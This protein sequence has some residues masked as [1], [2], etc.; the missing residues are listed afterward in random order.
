MWVMVFDPDGGGNP[1]RQTAAPVAVADYRTE[2]WSARIGERDRRRFGRRDAGRGQL[3]AGDFTG[4]GARGEAAHRPVVPSEIPDGQDA[5]ASSAGPLRR[6]RHPRRHH[7]RAGRLGRQRQ[8]QLGQSGTPAYAFGQVCGFDGAAHSSL[9]SS[10]RTPRSATAAARDH[11]VR[12][13]AWPGVRGAFGVGRPAYPRLVPTLHL[14]VRR[15]GRRCRDAGRITT[16]PGDVIGL[17]HR[18]QRRHQVL[19]QLRAGDLPGHAVGCRV[20]E[21]LTATRRAMFEILTTD[22]IA[23]VPLLIAARPASGECRCARLRATLADRSNRES[24][25]AGHETSPFRIGLYSTLTGC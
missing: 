6:D 21:E 12:A 4:A 8:P 5:G 14:D 7:P 22:P 25:V 9:G 16:Q 20:A 2:P 1:R 3:R 24:L 17:V 11:P 10:P 15:A 18:H 23:G 19:L 13:A